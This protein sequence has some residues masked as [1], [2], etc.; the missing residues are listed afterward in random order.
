VKFQYTI[1]PFFTAPFAPATIKR[2]SP[3]KRGAG[4][5]VVVPAEV[6]QE[7]Q[8]RATRTSGRRAAIVYLS[9]WY[10]NAKA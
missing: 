1:A 3:A 4:S 6:D 5:S 9:I 8:A 10:K 2:G 7:F